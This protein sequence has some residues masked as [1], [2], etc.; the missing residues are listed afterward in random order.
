MVALQENREALFFEK[1][2]TLF[3]A[4]PETTPLTLAKVIS[5]HSSV[6]AP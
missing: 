1:N 2:R 5:A 6:A 4:K 3:F